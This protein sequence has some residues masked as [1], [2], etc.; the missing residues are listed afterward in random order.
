MS[1]AMGYQQLTNRVVEASTMSEP[2]A[3]SVADHNG[4]A[5][6]RVSGEIDAA[7]V[8]DFE[9]AVGKVLT[10]DPA[11]LVIELSAVDYMGSVGLRV[12]AATQEQVGP[13]DGFAVVVDNPVIIKVIRLTGLDQ[14]FSLY[15]NL[16]DAL[17]ALRRPEPETEIP[18]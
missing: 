17:T 9:T 14:I 2:I 6:V 15:A 7:T 5:V 8:S 18:S 4:I 1:A 13:T 11:G 10:A 12:L 3:T 16:Q